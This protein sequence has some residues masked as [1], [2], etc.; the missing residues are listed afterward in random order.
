MK[1]YEFSDYGVFSDAISTI[2]SLNSKIETIQTSLSSLKSVLNSDSVFAGPIAD[3]C[4]EA[5]T[6]I[7]SNMETITENFSKIC[8]YLINISSSYISGDNAASSAILELNYN[9]FNGKVASVA[10][11]VRSVK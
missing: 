4:I 10:S 2:E 5:L 11:S 3:N 7:E 8:N 6:G 1:E 9:N